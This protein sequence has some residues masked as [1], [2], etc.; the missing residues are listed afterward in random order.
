MFK[1][2]SELQALI[3]EKPEIV[4]SGIP[5]ISPDYCLDVPAVISLGREIPLTSGPIDNLFIDANAILTFVECKRYGDGRLKREVYSQ[6]INYASDL[7]QMFLNFDEE[8]FDQLFELLSKAQNCRFHS[9]DELCL[10]LGKDPILTGKD[11]VHWQR[12]FKDRLEFNIKRGIF[13]VVILCG[14]SPS[15]RFSAQ[16]VRNLMQIMTFAEKESSRYDLLLMDISESTAKDISESTA[17]RYISRIIWRRYAP[18]PQIPLLAIASR[19]TS[20]GIEAMRVRRATMGANNPAAENSLLRLLDMLDEGGY[21]VQENTHGLALFRGKK[22]I[23][24]TIRIED[25]GWTINR[26]QIRRGETLHSQIEG[27]SLPAILKMVD[28]SLT[29]KASS[30]QGASGTMYDMVITPSFDLALGSEVLMALSPS[31]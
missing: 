1:S 23:F 3:H 19:D 29:T 7:Q 2:E 17:N 30:A 13:R 28:F 11:M 4:L 27:E 10:E 5:E 24:T 26:H 22:S 31:S 6:A 16:M 14:A 21:S 9:L 25:D 8:F 15:L 12:Q 18:L 20:Q